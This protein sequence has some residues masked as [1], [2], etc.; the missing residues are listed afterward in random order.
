MRHCDFGSC[1]DDECD[2]TCYSDY[3]G[4]HEKAQT[5]YLRD[6]RF[7]LSGEDEA[8][9]IAAQEQRMTAVMHFWS[10]LDVMARKEFSRGQDW[11]VQWYKKYRRDSVSNVD[12]H[13]E[14]MLRMWEG[15]QV[16]TLKHI[17]STVQRVCMGTLKLG[18][19]SAPEAVAVHVKT[20]RWFNEWYE[21]HCLGNTAVTDGMILFEVLY[22]YMCL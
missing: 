11:L 7:M 13:K 21:W 19:L 5:R 15:E 8:A 12:P 20:Q 22:R 2:G 3:M 14:A 1:P 17:A 18:S 9:A 6:T 4:V 16:R 10:V